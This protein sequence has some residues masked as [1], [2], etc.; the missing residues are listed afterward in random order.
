MHLQVFGTQK[1]E[2]TMKKLV[3]LLFCLILTLSVIAQESASFTIPCQE[4]SMG[5]QAFPFKGGML[6]MTE[7]ADN[8]F[9]LNPEGTT[10][11]SL[12][13]SG[14]MP[15]Q[16]LEGKG[17]FRILDFVEDGGKS[18]AIAANNAN[19]YA[20]PVDLFAN[21]LTF[22][23]PISLDSEHRVEYYESS[24]DGQ[25]GSY[26]STG[27][28][29]VLAGNTLYITQ[30]GDEGFKELDSY[31]I[32]TG[33]YTPCTIKEL[34]NIA[35][36]QDG[37]LLIITTDSDE[38]YAD[39]AVLT[40]SVLNP[41][42]LTTEEFAILGKNFDRYS[43]ARIFYEE[44][45]NSL[46]YTNNMQVFR[47]D[48]NGNEELCGFKPSKHMELI[49][50]GSGQL[51]G[52]EKTSIQFISTEISKLPTD[53][54][55]MYNVHSD[56]K[57]R[58]K[59]N[60]IK[61]VDIQDYQDNVAL[62]QA[63]VSGSLQMDVLNMQT[64]ANSPIPFVQKGYLANLKDVP[65]VKEYMN[66]LYPFLAEPFVKD[67]AI[68]AIPVSIYS[69]NFG[70]SP[71]MMEELDYEV[72]K[73]FQEFCHI[74][75]DFQE[76]HA[77]EKDFALMASPISGHLFFYQM[78]TLYLNTR[79]QMGL[80]LVLDTPEFREMVAAYESLP[81]SFR[82]PSTKD[83]NAEM[84]ELSQKR[85][86]FTPYAGASLADI[87]QA[88]NEIDLGFENSYTN[89]PLILSAWDGAPAVQKFY[90]EYLCVF[91]QSPNMG[92]A[93][94]YIEETIKARSE[95]NLAEVVQGYRNPI[96]DK[97][98]QKTMAELLEYMDAIQE[99]IMKAEGAQKTQLE[100]EYDAT[101]QKLELYEKYGQY[102]ISTIALDY[103]QSVVMTAAVLDISHPLIGWSSP[104]GELNNRYCQNQ[105]T[106]EQ[107][108]QEFDRKAKLITL[109]QQ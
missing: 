16:L 55:R 7:N 90:A 5:V 99:K 96:E 26:L 47:L 58:T 108:I 77:D 84:R 46:V 11:I 54:L 23:Q 76:N 64:N 68:Y 52:T 61:F 44:K 42:N 25:Q 106:I 94:R 53:S 67:G 78:V 56:E 35:P 60:D 17:F 107:L 22:S 57:V 41:E 101:K 30:L 14:F 3:V 91:A 29:Y 45:T 83:Y 59:M 85:A 36:Y 73:T 88:L 81:L 79:L 39:N 33:E 109:E 27:D 40:A 38:L 80:P 104:L 8:Y 65:G 105:I 102:D 82:A 95:Q 31:N 103:Y 86:L 37:K 93:K 97:N 100:M 49:M 66:S 4:N 43:N 74:I 24:S 32:L 15:E 72:P 98:R 34:I 28:R 10:L 1:K 87:T 48:K 51:V 50:L 71:S 62:G 2:E 70:Y 9:Y 12:N 13:I 89:L 92:N 20:F 6:C 18:Y 19:M 69:D 21:V 75:S 63:M